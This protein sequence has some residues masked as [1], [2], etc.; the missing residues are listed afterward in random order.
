MNPRAAMRRLVT[1]SALVVLCGCGAKPAAR[2]RDGALDITLTDFR[3][4]PQ[5]IDARRGRLTLRVRDAGR[6]PHNIS[7]RGRGGERVVVSTMLPGERD[8]ATITLKPGSYRLFCAI[9]NHEE[10]GQYAT[11]HVR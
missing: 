3:M 1:L 11:L 9:A 8:Q 5:V 7:I 4:A 6:L 2:P 10:L